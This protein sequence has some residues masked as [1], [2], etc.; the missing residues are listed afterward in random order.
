M[1]GPGEGLTWGALQYKY[2]SKVLITVL[3]DTPPKMKSIP[4]VFLGS[5]GHSVP[6][7]FDEGGLDFPL[8]FLPRIAYLRRLLESWQ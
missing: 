4:S 5:G 7:M 2:I 6:S 3:A 1:V 8:L